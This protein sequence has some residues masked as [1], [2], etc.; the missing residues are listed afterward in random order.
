LSSTLVFDHPTVEALVDYLAERV[1]A[2][3]EPSAPLPQV[4]PEPRLDTQQLALEALS[5]DELAE[6]LASKL[7]SME[8]SG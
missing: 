7:A 2:L 8:Q 6:L 5:Q 3:K 1:F 4:S